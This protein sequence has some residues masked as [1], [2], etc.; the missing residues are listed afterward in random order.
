M[1]DMLFLGEEKSSFVI[2]I[3]IDRNKFNIKVQKGDLA[4]SFWCRLL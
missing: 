1:N 4:L 3:G 2:L